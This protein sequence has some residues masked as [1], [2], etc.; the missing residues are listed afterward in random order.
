MCFMQEIT[1]SQRRAKRVDGV[2]QRAA[3]RAPNAAAHRTT[4]LRTLFALLRFMRI[5]C[6]HRA[7]I[8]C[9]RSAAA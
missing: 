3:Q 5:W 7:Y 6:L 4:R 2:A 9:T 8:S 1:F